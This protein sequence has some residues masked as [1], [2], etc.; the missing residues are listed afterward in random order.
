MDSKK[1][2]KADDEIYDGPIMNA[3]YVGDELFVF[4]EGPIQSTIMHTLVDTLNEN[5]L[6]EGKKFSLVLNSGGGDPAFLMSFYT[7]AKH[8]GLRAIY[9]VGQA[10]S[11]ALAMMLD[12]KRHRMPIY[13]DPMCYVVLHRVRT[14]WIGEERSERIHDYTDKWIKPYE[15]RFDLVNKQLISKLTARQK[16][17]YKDGRDVYLL[18]HH[19]IDMGIFKEIKSGIF[20][21][22]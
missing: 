9:G 18:G 4:Y 14:T 11:A 10:S 22:K 12:C 6:E 8:M 21:G 16:K 7:F 15:E 13:I 19:L 3:R 1:I 17:D 5:R 20:T 2:I